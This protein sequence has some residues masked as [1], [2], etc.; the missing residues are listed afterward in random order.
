MKPLALLLLFATLISC[1]HQ[2][3]S[4][5]HKQIATELKSVSDPKKMVT[6]EG[7]EYKPFIGKDKAVKVESFLLDE[8]AVSNED[9]LKFLKANP[10]WSKSE[11]LRLYA[12]S[13]Y[14]KNWKSDFEIPQGVDP[15]GPVTN[16][17]WYAAKAYAQSVG[18]RLPTV[19]EWEFAAAADETKK[20]ASDDPE[21]ILKIIKLYENKG[22]YKFATK[23]ARPNYWGVY[24]MYGVIWEWTED[25]NSVMIT[26][27]SRKDNTENE[28][29][30]CAGGAITT[31]DL[32]NYAAFMRFAMRGSV[33]ASYTVNNLGFRCAKDLN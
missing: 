15:K 30:F 10:Q 13:T 25:F 26:G 5:A 29:L 2:N 4:D 20:N 24:D 23:Q 31:T 14:L 19:D 18:K 3:H 9:F 1:Q 6:I 28:S 33:K 21:F 7:G 12:D 22:K 16:V 8:T 32:Q 11:V 27:E 17:S